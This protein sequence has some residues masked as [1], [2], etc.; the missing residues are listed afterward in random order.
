M[1]IKRVLNPL[2]VYRKREWILPNLKWLAVH[3]LDR[4]GII[5]TVRAIRGTSRVLTEPGRVRRERRLVADRAARGI[6]RDIEAF[7]PAAVKRSDTLFILGS[8][9]SID[10]LGEDDWRL[11]AEHDSLGINFWPIHPFVPTYY[12]Y[13]PCLHEDRTARLAARLRTRREDYSRPVLFSL[14][15]RW[16]EMDGARQ[17]FDDDFVARTHFY[18]AYQL[19]TNSRI[20]VA[21]ALR[22]WA[23]RVQGRIGDWRRTGILN[24]RTTADA[25]TCFGYLC[26]YR[27]LVLLGVDLKNSRYFWETD[28]SQYDSAY[29]PRNL[30][31]S[32]ERPHAVATPHQLGLVADDYLT[33]FDRLVLR[34]S[35]VQLFV[36]SEQS[37]LYPRI[38]LF[39]EFRRSSRPLARSSAP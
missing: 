19:A 23:A 21:A 5:P 26:G 13:E 14:T 31:D 8:G 38:P 34:P 18:S 24:H 10:E 12:F 35:G 33:L 4:V 30:H 25:A 16:L 27:R 15:R 20:V 17:P 2:H 28:P 32:P 1:N 22:L 37:K 7:D 36:G 6:S 11:I 39:P 3:A 9:S 29:L